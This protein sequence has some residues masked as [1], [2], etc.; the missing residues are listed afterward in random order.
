[1]KLKQSKKIFIIGST[2]YEGK[3]KSYK[4]H[5]EFEGHKVRLC[6]F[7]CEGLTEFE[8]MDRNRKNIRWADEVHIFWDG[9]SIGTIFDIGM[10]FA[11]KK[12]LVLAYLNKK[13]FLNFLKEACRW[14]E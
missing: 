8:I 7:D 14:E 11:L 5:L 6:Q 4:A 1:M 9:R 10:A 13:H 12:T 3:M 2:A